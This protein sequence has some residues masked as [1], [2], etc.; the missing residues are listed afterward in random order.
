M[1]SEQQLEWGNY[2]GIGAVGKS[3]EKVIAVVR[4]LNYF[5]IG[6]WHTDT[7][8]GM[9]F[10]SEDLYT[11]IMGGW[12]ARKPEQPFGLPLPPIGGKTWK[13]YYDRRDPTCESLGYEVSAKRIIRIMNRLRLSD[14]ETPYYT[15]ICNQSTKSYA[16]FGELPDLVFLNPFK[17]L[18]R[19]T[20]PAGSAEC[21]K[22]VRTWIDPRPVLSIRTYTTLAFLSNFK[23]KNFYLPKKCLRGFYAH[24]AMKQAQRSG[25][26]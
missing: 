4:V 21:L 5:P 12:G 1:R 20:R 24:S 3:G 19:A 7:R 26:K 25:K 6:S 8:A 11:S 13:A 10:D 23:I 9:F 18:S 14:P 16:F 2:A 17:I 22:S 15:N